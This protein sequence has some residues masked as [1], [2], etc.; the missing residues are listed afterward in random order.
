LIPGIEP[1]PTNY[2]TINAGGDRKELPE[3][4][5][6]RMQEYCCGSKNSRL[7]D[8][9][10]K[11]SWLEEATRGSFG[12]YSKFSIRKTRHSSLRLSGRGRYISKYI[13]QTV[14][15]FIIPCNSLVKLVVISLI[16][17]KN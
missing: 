15:S 8:V 4:K 6:A 7:L 3:L 9:V 10:E 2:T 14:S 12:Q 1:W 13:V 11:R 5:G 16:N 17:V